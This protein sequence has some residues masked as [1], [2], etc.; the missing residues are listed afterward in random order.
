[1]CSPNEA[2][3]MWFV[4]QYDVRPC[5]VNLIPN[6][7]IEWCT[8]HAQITV[9]DITVGARRWL[10][11][12]DDTDLWVIYLLIHCGIFVDTLWYMYWYIVIFLLIHCDIFLLIHCDIFIDTLWHILIYCEIYWY[13]VIYL[14]IHC[15]IF[16]DALW[17]IFYTL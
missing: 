10:V 4:I 12:D 9:M 7:D 16:I 17:Y 14:L 15:D 8:V 2:E 1:M 13:I 5:G 6:V 11:C 3:N